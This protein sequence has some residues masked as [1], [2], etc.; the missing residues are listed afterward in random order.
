MSATGL[1]LAFLVMGAGSCVQGMVGFG[2]SLIAAPFLL[3]IDDRF[4]PGPITV[5]S[6]G[7]NLVPIVAGRGGVVD[8]EVRWAIAG[9][10]PGTLVGGAILAALSTEVLSIVFAGLVM[11]AVALS[12]SGLHPRRTPRSL[13]AAGTASGVMGTVSGI[14]G[15]PI[16]LVYQHEPAALLRATL[17]RFFLAGSLMSIVAIAASGHLGVDQIGPSIV[18]AAAAQAGWLVS[19]QLVHH[20]DGRSARPVVLALSVSAA[21]AVVVRQVLG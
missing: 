21:A 14:G 12:L 20:V 6:V 8:R 10:V 1:V 18:L 3:L 13:A 16:A 9:L 11:I 7:L 19:K 2:A 4:V 15:P 17:P 5:A